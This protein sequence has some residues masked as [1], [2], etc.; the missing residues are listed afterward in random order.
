MDTT[1]A[2]AL[3][4]IRQAAAS[5]DVAVRFVEQRRWAGKPTC[6]NCGGENVYAM[7]DRDGGREKH[8]RWRCRFEEC[9]RPMF[10]VRTATVMEESRLPLRFWVHAFW[11]ACA[12]KKGVSAMQIKR[13]LGIN[14]K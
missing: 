6:P 10:T 2:E 13:E 5:E 4:A 8:F 3:D 14:Y 7:R 1:E 12:S 11:R 9:P